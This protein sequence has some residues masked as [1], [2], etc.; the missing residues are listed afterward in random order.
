MNEQAL[1]AAAGKTDPPIIHVLMGFI[2]VWHR[3]EP[4]Q[5]QHED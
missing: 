3:R 4:R 5:V 1:A 2:C